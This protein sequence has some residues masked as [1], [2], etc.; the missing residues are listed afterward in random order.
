[1]LGLFFEDSSYNVF[2][3][4][5]ANRPYNMLKATAP[6]IILSTNIATLSVVNITSTCAGT[7]CITVLSWLA[8]N[9]GRIIQSVIGI[10][11]NYHRAKPNP[12]PYGTAYLCIDLTYLSLN[13]INGIDIMS[14]IMLPA[15]ICSINPKI[16]LSKE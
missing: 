8:S 9:I 12:N 2:I 1:M 6:I 15:I 16:I 14:P 11:R 7:S 3:I 13:T 4:I 5:A 10:K